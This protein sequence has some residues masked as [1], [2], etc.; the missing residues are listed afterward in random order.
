VGEDRVTIVVATRDRRHDLE[1]SLPRH[2]ANVIVVD[3]GSVDGTAAA[4]RERHPRMEVVELGANRGAPARNVGVARAD[5]PYVAF[6]DDDSWWAPGALALAADV[7]DAHPRLA[8]L[9]ARVLVGTFQ[10][11]DPTC[12]EMATAPLGISAGA[13]GPAVLGFIA[14]GAVVR[15]EAFLACGGFDEVVFFA[16]E[17]ERVALDLAAAGWALAYVPAVVAC[18]HPS[19]VRDVAQRRALVVRNAVLVAVLRRPWPVVGHR[20]V[21]ALRGGAASRAGLRAALPRIPRALARRRRLPDGVESARRALDRIH[22]SATLIS[23]A[24]SPP[25]TSRRA[26]SSG[27]EQGRVNAAGPPQADGDQART[28]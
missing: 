15:R 13:P 5:T 7:L 21:D 12:S 1:R 18:H 3:N 8:V 10:R 26:A 4:V 24:Q 22:R 6:A 11:L 28:K 2:E 23:P 9:A 25:S 16:G 19:P 27:V 20:M 17:E 14:C